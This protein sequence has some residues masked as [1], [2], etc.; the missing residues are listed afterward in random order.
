MNLSARTC[1]RILKVARTILDPADSERITADQI[2]E[3]IQFRS[4]ER[5]LCT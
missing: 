5:Q 1:D 4:L 3:A 2:G